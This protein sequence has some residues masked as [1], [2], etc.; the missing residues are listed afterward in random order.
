MQRL[1][2]LI[3]VVAAATTTAASS[4][5]PAAGALLA[6]AP[7]QD[8]ATYVARSAI[9]QPGWA[10]LAQDAADS[11]PMVPSIAVGPEHVVQSAS[12]TVR[13]TDRLGSLVKDIPWADF[14]D[15]PGTYVTQPTFAY[16]ARHGRWIALAATWKCHGPPGAGTGYVEIAVSDSPDPTGNWHQWSHAW[17]GA[18]PTIPAIGTSTSLV[19]VVVG[20]AGMTGGSC[21]PES[22]GTTSYWGWEALVLDWSSILALPTTL[23]FA[24]SGLTHQDYLRP[25][26]QTP[27]T[28]ATLYFV[29]GRCCGFPVTYLTVNGSVAK[30][31]IS[32][33][34][35]TDLTAA[36]VVPELNMYTVNPSQPGG[37]VN[38]GLWPAIS[39]AVW[40]S[41]RLVFAIPS[42]CWP[43]GD[44]EY[45]N[46]VRVVELGTNTSTPARH[47][48]V[49]IGML[50]RDSYLGGIA[51]SGDGTIHVAWDVSSPQVGDYVSSYAARILPG[52]GAAVVGSPEPVTA[53]QS[54]YAGFGWFGLQAVT[55]DPM[56]AGAA[57]QGAPVAGSG[58]LWATG[59]SQLREPTS[60][61]TGPSAPGKATTSLRTATLAGSAV[62]VALK[63]TASAD[64]GSGLG[65]VPYVVEASVDGGTTWTVAGTAATSHGDARTRSGGTVR[66]RVVA[67]DD[68]GNRTPGSWSG[69]RSIRLTQQSSSAITYH[70][71]WTKSKSKAYSGGSVRYAKSA[72]AS[73][74]YRFTGRAI[75]IVSTRAASRGKV[76]VY[77]NGH[78]QAE[79]SL[80]RSSTLARLVVWQT[81]WSTSKTRTVKLVVVGGG[82]HP[83]VD[84]DAFVVVH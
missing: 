83:R 9:S 10:G 43:D 61:V 70:G 25:V 62:P 34:T 40:H 36:G 13:I 56:D 23:P 32:F 46:C 52:D 21:G 4:A 76:K 53:G 15:G 41:N 71:N 59:V 42:A 39:T 67:I 14:F 31:T 73:A 68:A 63:W 77:V 48:D 2:L 84:L 54:S 12:Q 60:D 17:E 72:G 24:T 16:D 28:S 11:S 44:T 78:L 66:W 74:S 57:W 3:A 55:A 30:G 47:R 1:A 8:L 19:A 64:S 50:G 69:S 82:H 51:L 58:G 75:G 80:H 22:D 79:V 6:A 18:I 38:G 33:S 27:A 49:E 35:P 20:V 81:S 65:P 45:R 26:I 29:G 5:V 37:D 7:P